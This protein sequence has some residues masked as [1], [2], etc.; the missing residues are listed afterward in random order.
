LKPDWNN[1]RQ[2]IFTD[3]Y[4]LKSFEGKLKEDKP[5]EMFKRIADKIGKDRKEKNMYYDAL[6]DFSFVPA[7]RQ[8]AG[9]GSGM[10]STF[11]N[12]YYIP[13]HN[14]SNPEK[15]KDSRQAIM[16]TMSTAVEIMARGG[17]K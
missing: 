2:N 4:A 11:F 12:C 17:G 3:R 10:T 7:G 14:R 13:F 8:L 15:G 9:I 5:E 1:H 6:N 16:D